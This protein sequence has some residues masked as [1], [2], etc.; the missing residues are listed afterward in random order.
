[1]SNGHIQTVLTPSD[2]NAVIYKNISR[3]SNIKKIIIICT[4]T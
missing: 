2:S 3:V 4:E 1:M